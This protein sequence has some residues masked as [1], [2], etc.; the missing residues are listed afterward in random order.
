[1]VNRP[2]PVGAAAVVVPRHPVRELLLQVSPK[3]VSG[4]L[5][6]SREAYET[7]E[8]LRHRNE[9]WPPGCALPGLPVRPEDKIDEHSAQSASPPSLRVRGKILLFPYRAG[10]RHVALFTT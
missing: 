3:L 2:N 8:P 1:M 4:C 10:V 6:L 5:D 7:E 9:R